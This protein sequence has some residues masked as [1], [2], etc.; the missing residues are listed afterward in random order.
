[1][2]ED[3]PHPEESRAGK[4]DTVGET[5]RSTSYDG[6]IVVRRHSRLRLYIAR[7]VT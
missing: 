2:E 6:L 7:H 4:T 1:M 3:C 5:N